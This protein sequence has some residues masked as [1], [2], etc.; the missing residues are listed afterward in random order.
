MSEGVFQ[1]ADVSRR[2]LLVRQ[3]VRQE[4]TS[5]VSVA[6]VQKSQSG[7]AGS[8]WLSCWPMSTI[9][10]EAVVCRSGLCSR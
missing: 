9:A 8:A 3:R 10:N 2:D 4:I 5:G 1:P 6:L 7:P